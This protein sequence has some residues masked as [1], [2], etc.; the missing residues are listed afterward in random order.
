M[1]H[2]VLKEYLDKLVASDDFVLSDALSIIEFETDKNRME[3]ALC[4]KVAAF[5]TGGEWALDGAKTAS[6]WIAKRCRLPI[7]ESRRQV[8]RGRHL[9]LLP[10]FAQAWLA[11]EISGAHLDAVIAIRRVATEDDLARDEEILVGLA[12][13]LQFRDFLTALERWALLAD[14]DGATESDM[15][16]RA[17]RDAY[18]V[19]TIDGMWVGHLLLDPVSGE[20]LS[21]GL[22]AI[23]ERLF[24]EDWAQA[25]AELG[26]DPHPNEMPRTP[27]Q[28]R[29]DAWVEMSTLARSVPENARRPEPLVSV[30]VDYEFLIGPV[31]QLAKSRAALSPGT[32]LD[33]IDEAYFERIVFGPGRRAECS[34]TSRF[35]TGATRRI[36]EVRDQECCHEYCDVPSDDCEADHIIPYSQGGLTT[37][38]N[39]RMMCGEHNRD[40]NHAPHLV[41]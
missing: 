5:D 31:C 33:L 8:R 30:L 11:G 13:T 16:R 18:L 38:E 34:V 3:A 7:Q 25:K 39:G 6:S 14:P 37:Q 41:E 29:C 15:E 9:T 27:G 23:N 24:E 19:Q 20:E 32:F 22:E 26:R 2:D 1:E 36:L 40:R 35:F 12:K 28:R 10:F 21:N 17:R 4:L